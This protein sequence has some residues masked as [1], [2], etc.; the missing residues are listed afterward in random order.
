MAYMAPIH[1][2]AREGNV[3]ALRR[4]LA[5]GVSPD[6]LDDNPGERWSPLLHLLEHHDRDDSDTS[7]RVACFKLLR[8]AGANL[9]ARTG[10]THKPVLYFTL[11]LKGEQQFCRFYSKRA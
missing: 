9:E 10:D 4:I 5:G 11:P 1:K 6:V 3:A 2:A 8:D 7:D